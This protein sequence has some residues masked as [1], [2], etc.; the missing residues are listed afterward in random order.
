MRQNGRP[1]I[2]PLSETEDWLTQRERVLAA[3]VAALRGQI[4]FREEELFYIRR[5]REAIEA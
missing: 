1:L 5:A 3:R 4:K 2:M